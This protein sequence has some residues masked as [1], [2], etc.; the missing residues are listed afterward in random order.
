MVKIAFSL[1]EQ[2][3]IRFG[4]IAIGADR[5]TGYIWQFLNFLSKFV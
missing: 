5:I 2:A 3:N 1:A 4:K